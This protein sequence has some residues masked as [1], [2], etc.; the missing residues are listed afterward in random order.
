MI[1]DATQS[2][3]HTTTH[4]HQHVLQVLQ[5]LGSAPL[6]P[7]LQPATAGLLGPAALN[8]SALPLWAFRTYLPYPNASFLPTN[9]SSQVQ[10]HNVTLVLPLSDWAALLAAALRGPDKLQSGASNTRVLVSGIQELTVGKVAP[11]YLSGNPAL[12]VESY[13]G[14][15]VSGRNL[16]LLPETPLPL[17]CDSW[18]AWDLDSADCADRGWTSSSGSGS[19]SGRASSRAVGI[20]V[21]V[22]VGVPVLL[23]LVGAAVLLPGVRR[24]RAAAVV[25]RL[26]AGREDR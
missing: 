3:K 14:W 15:G 21:G 17:S 10:L 24:R 4:I 23:V 19:G 12:F 16:I 18:A 8:T 26:K 6:S 1:K 25:A 22:G 9:D 11:D 5:G 20:G 7:L 13:K 2:A